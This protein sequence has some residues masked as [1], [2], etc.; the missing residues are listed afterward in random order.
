MLP[1]TVPLRKCA[2]KNLKKVRE[3]DRRVAERRMF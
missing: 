3:W 2:K 1:G